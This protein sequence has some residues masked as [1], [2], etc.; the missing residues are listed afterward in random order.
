M[1]LGANLAYVY[2]FLEISNNVKVVT[3]IQSC[4]S[5]RMIDTGMALDGIQTCDCQ[6]YIMQHSTNSAHLAGWYMKG[7]SC[8]FLKYVH[9]DLL[10]WCDHVVLVQT[11]GGVGRSE[12]GVRTERNMSRGGNG[13][14][15]WKSACIV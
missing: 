15:T 8:T 14:E 2:L 4:K 3:Y 7:I 13:M 12:Y 1:T 9:L 10:Q 5:P 6:V 11:S